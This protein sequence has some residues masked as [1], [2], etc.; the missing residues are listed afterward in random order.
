LDPRL[1]AILL[2]VAACVIACLT[3]VLLAAHGTG[4]SAGWTVWS[5]SVDT[6]GYAELLG[7]GTGLLVAAVGTLLLFRTAVRLRIRMAQ[8]TTRACIALEWIGSAI[9]IAT[10]ICNQL[11]IAISRTSEKR[12]IFVAVAIALVVVVWNQSRSKRFVP[13]PVEV[14]GDDRW[15]WGLFYVD[16]SD[17]ALFVQSR[18]GVGYT[19]NY[20]RMLAWPISLGLVAY[21]VIALFILPPHH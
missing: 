13:P 9:L 20:G 21:V 7:F 17:P 1:A 5:D 4:L 8:Y 14:G 18:C 16:R 6:H 11:G 15:R 3:A 19:L 10:I 12:I 2:P